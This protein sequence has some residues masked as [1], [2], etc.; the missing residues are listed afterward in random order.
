[1][2]RIEWFCKVP[3]SVPLETLEV[4]LQESWGRALAILDIIPTN[5]KLMPSRRARKN[6]TK[7]TA[8]NM[9]DHLE[10]TLTYLDRLE[11]GD[12]TFPG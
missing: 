7:R 4:V 9:L 8:R 10:L 12:C 1:M 6:P 2:S 5:L 11:T 3:L